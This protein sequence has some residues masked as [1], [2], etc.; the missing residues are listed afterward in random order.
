MSPVCDKCLSA[1]GSL[2]HL[3]WFCPTLHNYWAAI[4]EWLSKAYSRSIQP[5]HDLAVFGC[6][7]R[8]FQLPYDIQAALHLAMVVAKKLILL[9][10]KSTNSPCF[11][12]WLR[13]MLS[14]IQM[15]RL[16]LDKPNTRNR[17]FLRIWG[18]FLAQCNITPHPTRP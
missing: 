6:S 5:D 16:R 4:F 12:H 7:T 13:E 17:L 14:V 15:E 8:T 18:P 10:W 11:S 3:L 2:A 1:E 9:T